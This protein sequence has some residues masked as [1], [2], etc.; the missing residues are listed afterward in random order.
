MAT[1][2]EP[3]SVQEHIERGGLRAALPAKYVAGLILTYRCSIA[4][5]HCL[6]CCGPDLPDVAMTVD[7]AVRTILDFHEL[8]RVV[9]VAGGELSGV[10]LCGQDFSTAVD[11]VLEAEEHF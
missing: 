11:A 3:G 4:C 6:F 8:D 7:D 9:H 1:K 10:V 2:R 5:R